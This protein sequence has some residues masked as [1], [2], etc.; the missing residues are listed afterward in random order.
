MFFGGKGILPVPDGLEA[1]A[2]KKLDVLWNRH[3]ACSSGAV[4]QASCLF[5][6]G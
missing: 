1:T 4:E 2:H 6:R 3:L 5:F